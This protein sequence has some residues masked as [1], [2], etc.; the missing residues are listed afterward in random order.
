MT[1]PQG[2]FPSASGN[3][4][5]PL[6]LLVGGG[7][8]FV[9]SIFV[10]TA[11]VAPGFLVADDETE[12]GEGAHALATRIMTAFADQDKAELRSVACADAD[13]AV[14][15][16]I[17]QAP[18]VTAAHVTGQATEQ[19]GIVTIGGRISAGNDDIDLRLVLDTVG[20]AWCW[21]SVEVPGLELH[22]P[23]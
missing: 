16:A 12:D 10:F 6:V 19:G 11:W 20:D 22:P 18:G 15:D 17:Q 4:T 21:R 2:S 9:A 13:P 3:R 1:H 8:L 23:R 7:L 14:A 5:W